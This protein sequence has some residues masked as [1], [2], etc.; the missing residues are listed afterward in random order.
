ME[1]KLAKKSN[2]NDNYVIQFL[3]GWSYV[4]K[5][6]KIKEKFIAEKRFGLDNLTKNKMKK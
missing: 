6:L 2:L 4:E 1:I 5:G 3:D